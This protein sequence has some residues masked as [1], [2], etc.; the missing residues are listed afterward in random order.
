MQDDAGGREVATARPIGVF[1]S[2]VGGLSVLHAIRAELPH[3]DVI[4]V[5]DSGHAPYGDR[6]TSVVID[7]ALTISGFLVEHG[8]KAIVVACNTATAIA[9]DALRSAFALPIV[10]IE[11]AV[12]PASLRTH[13]RVV[14]VLATAGTSASDKMGRLLDSYGRAREG[15]AIQFITQPCPG[16][17]D[18]VERGDVGS[19]SARALVKQYVRPIVERGADIL[20]LGCTHYPFLRPL[21]QDV[22]GPGV[23]L[24]DPAVPVARELGRRLTAAGLPR[25]GAHHATYSFWTTGAV[26]EVAP[27][28][29]KLWGTTVDLQYLAR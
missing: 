13:S 24:I 17:A 29:G 5:G 7:R 22:A 10:A 21:I 9:V 2:G 16:L 6:P 18:L 3:E 12:K 11:P 26:D 27:I 20:V 4:Y 25:N 28:V 1:D 8:A 19:D 14:G 23:E 15:D